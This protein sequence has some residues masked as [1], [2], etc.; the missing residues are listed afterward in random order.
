MVYNASNPNLQMAD[1]A[2]GSSAHGVIGRVDSVSDGGSVG[3]GRNS[4]PRETE[5]DT[6]LGI[7]VTTA[8]H[9]ISEG[10]VVWLYSGPVCEPETV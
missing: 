8:W 9:S 4:R 10:G 2:R 1:T 5:D 7:C 3:T 6:I